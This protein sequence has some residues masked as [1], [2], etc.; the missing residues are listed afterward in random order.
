MKVNSISG[1]NIKSLLPLL[2]SVMILS[3]CSV[4][5]YIPEERMLYTGASLDLEAVDPI[6]DF[7]EIEYLLSDLMYPEPNTHILGMRP[8]LHFYYKSR[9]D[10]GWIYQFLN[11]KMGEEPVY[12]EQVDRLSVE[13]LIRNR[14]E[15]RGH[16]NSHITSEIHLDEEKKMASVT[17]HV[18]MPA[19]YR[20]AT[21]TLEGDSL[22]I[23]Q[24]IQDYLEE[25]V[26]EAGTRFDLNLMKLERERIDAYLKL[27]GY[28]NFNANFLEFQADTNRYEDKRFDLYLS[29][30]RDV[31]PEALIPYRI[32]DVLVYP[33]F[34]L[35]RDSAGLDS[36][37]YQGKIYIQEDMY[38]RPDRLDPFIQIQKGDYYNAERSKSTSRRVG[39]TGAYKFVNIRFAETDSTIQD[40]V[41]H[42]RANIFLSPLNKR[43]VRT[44]LQA[45]TKSNNFAGPSLVLNWSNRNLFQGGEIL[46]FTANLG[47]ETQFSR[48][49]VPGHNNLQ[50]SLESDLVFPRVLLPFQINT[51]WFD[52][53]IP[54]TRIS[55]NGEYIARTN[56]FSMS[57][58]SGTYGFFWSGNRFV[59]HDL[60]PI[61][62]TYLNLLNSTP[63]FDEIL[64]RNPFLQSSFDQ[65]FISGMTYSYTYNGMVDQYRKHQIFL[66][67][68][69][70]IAGNLLHLITGP[71]SGPQNTFLGLEYA[72]YAKSVLDIRYHVNLGH[73]QKLATRVLAGLGE[74]YGNSDV[75]PYSKQFY[76]G[77]P[78]SVRAFNTRQLGPGSYNPDQEPGDNRS[79]FDQ[80]GN[81]RLE[82]N[83]EYRFP[84]FSYLKGA[85]F[86]DAGN[87]WLTEEN[88]ALA[89]GRIGP[90]FLNEL[91]IGAGVGFRLDIQ[92]FV[93]RMDLGFPLHDPALP[94]GDRWVSTLD[95]PVLNLAIGYPF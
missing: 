24:H 58:V 53:S 89:G 85:I 92:S 19:S 3:A 52:Y 42:L 50:L 67:G 69:F 93:I 47:Y 88:A 32:R 49:N 13:D 34:T 25:S 65:Q 76:S 21:Y 30:K 16:F 73:G 64:D 23:H 54:K 80:T 45:V 26:F 37:P 70:D 20:M 81:L 94:A 48:K 77:G 59:T 60:N 87:V 66:N 14:L 5:K 8:G 72:Q 61:S 79:Y 74:P 71:G 33:N 29:L 7:K 4:R 40:T 86:I 91:G 44:Q 56:L 17:Y 6:E 83:V 68:Y 12:M 95:W 39:S 46:G 84:M 28:Y 38:F 51:D 15:N 41:G 1:A 27:R 9:S 31:P 11:R 2:A 43:S 63:E 82:A 90:D 55:L 78:Y 10:S 22:N 35:P 62:I 75:L 57:S 36:I 18:V